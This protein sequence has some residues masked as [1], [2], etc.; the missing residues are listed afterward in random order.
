[1]KMSRWAP[2]ARP[3]PAAPASWQELV[4][5]DR[6]ALTRRP[7]PRISWMPPIDTTGSASTTLIFSG[8]AGGGT[9]TLSGS[10]A[11]GGLRGPSLAQGPSGIK[12]YAGAGTTPTMTVT[13]TT[14]P[15]GLFSGSR[16][17]QQTV[18]IFSAATSGSA[19]AST[20]FR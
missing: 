20:P 1:E 3:S 6:Q 19:N 7:A 10:T 14:M 12:F 9:F 4:L 8:G 11:Q 15:A 17:S 5:G 13:A 2:P 16:S 18:Q